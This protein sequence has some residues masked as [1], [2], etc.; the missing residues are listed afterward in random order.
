MDRNKTSIGCGCDDHPPECLCDVII[1]EPTPIRVTIPYGIE[2]GDEIARFGKWDG[3][4]AHWFE[5]VDF[6]YTALW[7]HRLPEERGAGPRWLDKDVY[8][9]LVQRIRDGG[10]P[11]PVRN[12]IIDKFGVTI[13]KSYVTHLRKRLTLRGEL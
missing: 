3:T 4:L 12:E 11:T 1:K 5:L 9:F 2:Y 8:A 10:Q 6:A 13:H 7:K